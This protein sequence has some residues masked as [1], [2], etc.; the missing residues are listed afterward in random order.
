MPE[1]REKRAN[2]FCS[3][4]ILNHAELLL[5]KLQNPTYIFDVLAVLVRMYC[6]YQMYKKLPENQSNSDLLAPSSPHHSTPDPALPSIRSSSLNSSAVSPSSRGFASASTSHQLNVHT[7][8]TPFEPRLQDILEPFQVLLSRQPTRDTADPAGPLLLGATPSDHAESLK[9]SSVAAITSANS[10]LGFVQYDPS[11]FL[12]LVPAD[13]SASPAPSAS[14][15][16]QAKR[17]FSIGSRVPDDP[18]PRNPGRAHRFCH[19]CRHVSFNNPPGSAP[20]YTDRYWR[21]RCPKC[22]LLHPF[23][24][25]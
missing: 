16:Q 12:S 20:D 9:P 2:I 15:T 17:S 24:D 5:S 10:S 19:V 22:L 14:G 13:H 1:K 23:L 18:D 7:T 21:T 8:S 25:M 3:A 4:G 6:A 11:E